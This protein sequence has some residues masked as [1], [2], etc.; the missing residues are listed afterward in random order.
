MPFTRIRGDLHRTRN[1]SFGI[2]YQAYRY[3]TALKLVMAGEL[4]IENGEERPAQT[5][6]RS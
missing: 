1:R 3:L 6:R 2:D 5:R 4:A